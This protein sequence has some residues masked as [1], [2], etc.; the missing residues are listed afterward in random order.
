MSGL[1]RSFR[2]KT[3]IKREGTRGMN[4][5]K[6]YEAYEN[7]MDPR[8]SRIDNRGPLSVMPRSARCLV[9]APLGMMRLCHHALRFAA[10]LPCIVT[11]PFG[12]ISFVVRASGPR[13]KSG[14]RDFCRRAYSISR[15]GP[16]RHLLIVIPL[17]Q[18]CIT[19]KSLI[20][21]AYC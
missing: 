1:L 10:I 21:T 12:F 4:A 16:Q 2:T 3:T 14:A 8:A 13:H 6:I 9:G 7:K 5:F 19:S 20:P 11:S 15:A 18:Y 17:H